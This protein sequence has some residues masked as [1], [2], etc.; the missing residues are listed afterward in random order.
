MQAVPNS[1]RMNYLIL[2]VLFVFLKFFIL[3]DAPACM[4]SPSKSRSPFFQFEADFV[5]SL[6]C[7]PMGV[8]FKLDTCGIKLKLSHWNSF[9]HHERQ[10][11]VDLPC[12]TEQEIANY[13]W[14]L[15][16][17]VQDYTGEPPQD[18]PVDPHPL[19]MQTHIIP[20]E[21]AAKAQE[22][23][24]TLTIDQWTTLTSLQRFALI[25]LSRPSHE[26]RNFLPALRE[27]GL[28]T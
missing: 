5:E 18:L 3:S 20:S 12:K 24:I 7:I 25:K 1:H 2:S 19:W 21:T 23:G 26:N 10:A 27:F 6:R 8:R 28:A 16:R 11:L 14:L 17:L 9:S 13:R 15:E 4:N 22:L